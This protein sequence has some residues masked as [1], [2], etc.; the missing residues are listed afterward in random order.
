MEKKSKNSLKINQL[1]NSTKPINNNPQTKNKISSSLNNNV[2]NNYEDRPIRSLG[3]YN[4]NF[5]DWN[6]E[7]ER[8][9]DVIIKIENG[10][11]IEDKEEEKR[12]KYFIKKEK[13]KN[14][15]TIKNF[16]IVLKPD[17]KKECY[18]C[19]KN[20]TK[21]TKVRRLFCSHMFCENCLLP[22]LKYNSK[23]PVCKSDLNKKNEE[24]DEN[25]DYEI[26]SSNI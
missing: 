10:E 9:N 7:W 24:E 1:L 12:I 4:L 16:E 6:N 25:F 5:I 23:C 15:I 18:I 14:G 11:S 17:L 26:N 19:L 3:K 21:N 8:V 22:W 2:I 13:E 20:F